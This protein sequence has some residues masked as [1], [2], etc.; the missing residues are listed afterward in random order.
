MTGVNHL[1][2]ERKKVKEVDGEALE[3]VLQGDGGMLRH[4]VVLVVVVQH[5]KVRNFG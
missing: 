4:R 3:L 2:S 5:L 1:P